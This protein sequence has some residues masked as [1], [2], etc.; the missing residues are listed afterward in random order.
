M[1]EIDFPLIWAF[2]CGLVIQNN[3]HFL[4]FFMILYHSYQ[5]FVNSRKLAATIQ[6]LEDTLG[7]IRDALSMEEEA[8]EVE[9]PYDSH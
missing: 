3:L 1:F 9:E 8:P 5:N 7:R 2:S 6:K 4:V